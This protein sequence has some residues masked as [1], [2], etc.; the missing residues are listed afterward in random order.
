MAILQSGKFVDIIM[1][2]FRVVPPVYAE[3]HNYLPLFLGK[4]KSS[5]NYV[6]LQDIVFHTLTYLRDVL[7]QKKKNSS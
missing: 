4:K 3:V 6:L 7:I 2:R 5:L 1:P